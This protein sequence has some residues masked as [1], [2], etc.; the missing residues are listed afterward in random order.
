MKAL[1]D[2]KRLFIL[3]E[4]WINKSSGR[5]SFELV[6]QDEHGDETVVQEWNYFVFYPGHGFGGGIQLMFPWA[7]LANDEDKF[8]LYDRD[9]DE[10]WPDDGPEIGPYEDNGE[11]ASWRLELTLN[12][13]GKAFLLTDKHLSEKT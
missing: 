4:E 6:M 2:G 5:C 3:A 7:E 1:Q 12:E 13:L 8:G 11:T 10:F 9:E